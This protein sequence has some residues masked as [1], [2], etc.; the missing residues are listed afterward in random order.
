MLNSLVDDLSRA[1]ATA[2]PVHVHGACGLGR[3]CVAAAAVTPIPKSRGA[4]HHVSSDKVETKSSTAASAAVLWIVP[5]EQE[6]L[7]R[8][9]DLRF[10]L[11]DSGDRR[12]LRLPAYERTPFDLTSP[13]PDVTARRMAA[14]HHLATKQPFTA[15]IASVKAL[16]TPVP[17]PETLRR[18]SWELRVGQPLDRQKLLAD[19]AIGG[20]ARADVVRHVGVYAVRGSVIDLFW[21]G[22]DLPARLDLFGDR[23]ETLKLF[24]PVTQRSVRDLGALSIG[25]VREILWEE[26]LCEKARARMEELARRLDYPKAKLQAKLTDVANRLPFVGMQAL[27]PLFHDRLVAPLQLTRQVVGDEGLL[28]V[29][30]DP[31]AVAEA[32]A[33]VE[34]RYREAH[35]Q[36][37]ERGDLVCPPEEGLCPLAADARTDIVFVDR[38]EEEAQACPEGRRDKP[39]EHTHPYH[40]DERSEE[41]SPRV[42]KHGEILRPSFVNTQDR[43]RMTGEVCPRDTPAKELRLNCLPTE[44]LRRQVEQAGLRLH[45]DSAEAHPPLQPAADRLRQLRDQGYAVWLPVSSASRLEHLRGMLQ[46]YDLEPTVLKSPPPFPAERAFCHPD[47]RSE[48]GSPRVSISGEILRFAQNDRKCRS[49]RQ[50]DERGPTLTKSGIFL[51]VAR[52]CPPASGVVLP[53]L[54]LAVIAETDLFPALAKGRAGMTG[55]LL[56]LPD[57]R[58]GRNAAD[59]CRDAINRVSTSALP[60]FAEGD[61]VIHVEHGLG[62]FE[63]LTRMGVQGLEQDFALLTYAGGDKLY[64]PVQRINLLKRYGAAGDGDAVALDKLGSSRWR[65]RK[66][67]VSQAVLAM[68]HDLLQL[69]AKR[70]LARRPPHPRPD[71]L[72]TEFDSLFPFELTPDQQ[73]AEARVLA[74]MQRDRPMDRLLC[75]DVSYGKTEIAMRAAMLC[76]SGGRQVAVLTPTT[77][78]AQ[79]HGAVWQQRFA[80]LGATVAS[81]HR[82]HKPPRVREVI[83]RASNGGVD[84]LVGT[85]RLLSRDVHVPKLGLVVVDEEQRF[86]I[87]AKEHLRR[88]RNQCDVLTLSATPIPRTLQM[89]LLAL[90]DMSVLQTPPRNRL[91]IRTTVARF[92]EAVIREGIKR[93]LDRGGQVYFVHNRVRSIHAMADYIRRVCAGVTHGKQGHTVAVAHGQMQPGELQAV[94]ERFVQRDVDVLV[95]SSIIETGL[96][97][98]T[99]NTMFINHADDFGLSQLHQL[100]GR[101]GRGARQAFAY[102]LIP[103]SLQ[104]LTDQ[105]RRRLETLQRASDLGS[106]FTIAREDLQLR[107]AGDLL[108]KAQHGHMAAVGIDLYTTLLREAVEQLRGKATARVPDPEIKL[109]VQALIPPRYLPLLADRLTLYQRLAGAEREQDVWDALAAV[110]DRHGHLPDEVRALGHVMALRLP[111]RRIGVLQLTATHIPS[112]LVDSQ[113]PKGKDAIHRISTL[114]FTLG[115]HTRLDGTKLALWAGRQ[116]D[117]VRLQPRGASVRLVVQPTAQEWAACEGDVVALSKSV[118]E[119]L[120]ALGP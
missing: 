1:V 52:P 12:V 23:I 89:G 2:R 60:V 97:V 120:S 43:L 59:S 61:V 87:A 49:A 78:L 13:D 29:S 44:N 7:D 96:D 65:S 45:E 82:L 85:H 84:I 106:G 79:Q 25:P 33:R 31:R 93:E 40:P 68:A 14:V 27:L 67:K 34:E 36:A 72:Y 74:D 81:L 104:H 53:D 51:F 10:V 15:L 30:A 75:G 56:A 58:N 9:R 94:M 8:T 77:V 57:D 3:A 105:G 119:Q 71:A 20:Y 17:P 64:V 24:D 86:G 48:E 107:G 26:T 109:P 41:G 19:L 103:A 102:L 18:H 22:L 88:L 99:A 21:P 28:I 6:A 115:E 39:D 114:I 95:C 50:D 11:G 113:S 38:A 80:P 112:P 91:P 5:T 98:G 63:G 37:R 118:A 32:S 47:E 4:I 76:I 66:K 92:D 90:R 62:R 110:E 54:R 117:R 100:R 83:K 35:A 69:H 42:S 108:G 70:E 116:G 55:G 111:L 101:I 46:P 16:M 73:R